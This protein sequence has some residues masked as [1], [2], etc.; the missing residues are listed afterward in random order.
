MEMLLFCTKPLKN[1]YTVL[2]VRKYWGE[3][4]VFIQN[5]WLYIRKN[6][7]RGNSCCNAFISEAQLW[8]YS[9]SVIVSLHVKGVEDLMIHKSWGGMIRTERLIEP[10]LLL[11]WI[12]GLTRLF[13]LNNGWQANN[14]RE[15]HNIQTVSL[16]W[17]DKLEMLEMRS[18]G[19]LID[20]SWTE[21]AIREGSRESFNNDC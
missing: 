13:V 19:F 16:G 17:P 9:C 3:N 7:L 18:V 4:S 14:E 11:L 21:K 2:T 20:F 12:F 6:K 5:F 8:W 1:N 10:Q 15:W